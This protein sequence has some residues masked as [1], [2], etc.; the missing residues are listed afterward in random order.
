[1]ELTD[2]QELLGHEH[3]TTTAIYLQ[4]L[5]GST[6]EAIKKLEDLR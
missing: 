3:A 4:S 5:R 1:L 2:I 6:K